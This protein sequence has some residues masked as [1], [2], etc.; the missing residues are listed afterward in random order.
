MLG[1]S[2]EFLRKRWQKLNIMMF[3]PSPNPKNPPQ[4]RLFN[5]LPTHPVKSDLRKQLYKEM[6]FGGTRE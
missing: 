4:I 3:H 5:L 2:K 1:G 6:V